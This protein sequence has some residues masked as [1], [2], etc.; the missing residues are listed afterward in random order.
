[1]LAVWEPIGIAALEE[2]T[3][4]EQLE[5]LDRAGLLSIR[6]DGRRQRVSLAHPLYGEVLRARMPALTRRR[7]LIELADR[8]ET[9]G[10]RRR[11]DATRVAAARLQALGSAD[12]ELLLKA[13]RLARYALDFPQVERFA[14]AAAH[15]RDDRRVGLAARRGAARSRLL[16]RSR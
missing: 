8:L 12:P 11:E 2:M 4:P 10:G 15:A 13:A 3:G 9:I 5:L 6:V 7:L 16:H 14:R 1:M